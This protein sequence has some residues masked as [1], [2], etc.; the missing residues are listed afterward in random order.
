M[1][2]KTIKFFFYFLVTF[3]AFSQII[4]SQEHCI[5]QPDSVYKANK[6]KKIKWHMMSGLRATVTLDKEGR[7]IEYKGEPVTYGGRVSKF[8][9]YDIEG[10]LIKQFEK[11]KDKGI[12][13]FNFGIKY[14]DNV[15][16][17]L[18]K[19][20]PDGSINQMQYY[21]NKGR[22]ITFERYENEEIISQSTI[23]YDANSNRK[24]LSAWYYKPNKEKIEYTLT[25]EYKIE[26]G[27]IIQTTEYRNGVKKHPVHFLYDKNKLL[28]KVRYNGYEE[29]YKYKT[30]K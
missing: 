30:Y 25:Y 27:Q 3:F 11:V 9:E 12:Q 6:I 22:L 18:T 15:L 28:K 4:L 13:I 20:N 7:W 24:K 23:E 29:K 17:K 10:K 5:R 8:F 14:S 21:D 16:E 26:N 1:I 19:F 2:T